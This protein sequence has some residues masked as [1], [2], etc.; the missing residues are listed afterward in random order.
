MAGGGIGREE[1]APGLPHHRHP[2]PGRPSVRRLLP[3]PQEVLLK[4]AADL[5]E[6][7][8]GVPSGNQ[9]WR[10]RPPPRAGPGAARLPAP[11]AAPA[12]PALVFAGAPPEARGGR[13]RGSVQRPPRA[14]AARTPGAQPPAPCRRGHQRLQQ[15][16]G[17][18]RRGR[19][20]GAGARCVRRRP[21]A[22]SLR[23]RATDGRSP[24]GYARSCG[25]ASPRGFAPSPGSQQSGYG[26]SLGAGLGGY[27]APGVTG[28]GVPGSP[29][30]L[31]GSTAT[32]P[33]ASECPLPGGWG[34][35][36]GPGE[37]NE[38]Q[39]GPLLAYGVGRRNSRH[40]S[41]ERLPRR[42]PPVCDLSLPLETHSA[43]LGPGH[44]SHLYLFADRSC[45]H[46]F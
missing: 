16:A 27:G 32:S 5:A 36:P 20:A 34:E 7:L 11:A 33:F 18:R 10:L 24:A 42:C 2:R 4:R 35:G 15:P 17:H 14:G 12:V 25:S 6:A 29:S 38:A 3:C 31:N 21:E 40:L 13:G 43:T 39:L 37:Q 46:R 1:V 23:A 45:A 30:F 28:L 19:H 9:V 8:Y 26:G 41:L 44:F 22:P